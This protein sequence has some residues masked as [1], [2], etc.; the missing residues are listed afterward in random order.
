MRHPHA[1]WPTP[2]VA[3]LELWPDPS[4]GVGVTVRHGGRRRHMEDWLERRDQ[5]EFAELTFVK[6]TQAAQAWAIICTHRPDKSNSETATHICIPLQTGFGS[7]HCVLYCVCVCAFQ[8]VC[9]CLC[10]YAC[11]HWRSCVCV[12]VCVGPRV[13]VSFHGSL[14]SRFV[15]SWI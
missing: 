4:P 10:M 12:H 15:V 2:A 13:C 1:G 3:L 7:C 5:A 11:T 8:C 9:T 14:S 6:L